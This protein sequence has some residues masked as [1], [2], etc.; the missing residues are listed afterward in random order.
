MYDQ[1]VLKA[2]VKSLFVWEIAKCFETPS[3]VS[4]VLHNGLSGRQ[5]SQSYAIRNSSGKLTSVD[6][7]RVENSQPLGWSAQGR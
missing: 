6:S 3:A 5:A 7:R 1:L 2:N 4:S